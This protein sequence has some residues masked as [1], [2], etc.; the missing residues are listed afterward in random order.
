MLGFF[1]VSTV[2]AMSL[3]Y[4]TLMSPEACLRWLYENE[5]EYAMSAMT[6]RRLAL[7]VGSGLRA[8]VLP[9]R[10]T[11]RRRQVLVRPVDVVRYIQGKTVA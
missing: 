4:R 3:G 11:A 5:P 1:N 9:T 8:V 6:L 2:L 10:G 7:Q